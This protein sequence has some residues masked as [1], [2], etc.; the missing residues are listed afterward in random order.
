MCWMCVCSVCLFLCL[1]MCVCVCSCVC[2]CVSC[3]VAQRWPSLHLYISKYS[4]DNYEPCVVAFV[5]LYRSHSPSGV[6]V[7]LMRVGMCW[8]SLLKTLQSLSRCVH[9]RVCACMHVHVCV[10]VCV[11]MLSFILPANEWKAVNGFG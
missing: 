1:C 3:Q 6:L 8:W 4:N 7:C 5:H 9:A 10:H 2:M 11:G